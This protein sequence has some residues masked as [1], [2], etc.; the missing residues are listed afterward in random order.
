MGGEGARVMCL[1]IK[2]QHNIGGIIVCL[3][4]ARVRGS[5]ILHACA[6]ARACVIKCLSLSS[7]FCS[8]NVRQRQHAPRQDRAADRQRARLTSWPPDRRSL[9]A[10]TERPHTDF[11]TMSPTSAYSFGRFSPRRASLGVG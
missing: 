7:S 6:I 8:K 10:F 1:I 2:W 4:S 9:L 11:G 5:M 3:F